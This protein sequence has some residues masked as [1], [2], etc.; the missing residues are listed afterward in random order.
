MGAIVLAISAGIAFIILG[1]MLY[2]KRFRRRKLRKTNPEAYAA[3]PAST[4]PVMPIIPANIKT[5]SPTIDYF[6]PQRPAIVGA[7]GTRSGSPTTLNNN[8]TVSNRSSTHALDMLRGRFGNVGASQSSSNSTSASSSSEA[9]LQRQ[10]N[11]QSRV[12]VAPPMEIP[13]G[14]PMPMPMPMHMMHHQPPMQPQ[15][16]YHPQNMMPM[17]MPMQFVPNGPMQMHPMQIQAMQQGGPVNSQFATSGGP[18]NMD[19][20]IEEFDT[21]ARTRQARSQQANNN[22]G[23]GSSGG[24]GG[25]SPMID[26]GPVPEFM[27]D[28]GM[29]R[30]GENKDDLPPPSYDQVNIFKKQERD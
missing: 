14:Q 11:R 23:E 20:E 26:L 12:H 13:N 10:R 6:P 5:I 29:D 22:G 16:I 4:V 28:I 1:A 17:P 18:V 21:W 3:H 15:L 24:V 19:R 8:N 25:N 27:N 7:F 9:E 2:S 30:E